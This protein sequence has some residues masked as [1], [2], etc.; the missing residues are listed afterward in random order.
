MHIKRDPNAEIEHFEYLHG[1]TD[2]PISALLLSL[3]EQIETEGTILVWNQSF[4]KKRNE[5]MELHNPE[6]ASFLSSVNDRVMDLM[7]PFKQD[8]IMDPAFISSNSIKDVL[9]VMIPEF[10]YKDL[11]IKDG[12][13]A[14][15]EWQ[16]VT[17]SEAADKVTVYTDLK[18]Y[19]ERDTEAMV[20]IHEKLIELAQSETQK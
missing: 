16:R 7:D 2:C 3:S 5:E 8:L 11:E 19:C 20:L 1:N 14:A 18:K 17:L 6:Y 12:G 15:S 4:E 13:S 10:S 9:P